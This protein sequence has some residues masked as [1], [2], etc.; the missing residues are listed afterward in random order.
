ME[1][2][3]DKQLLIARNEFNSFLA[4][5][6]NVSKLKLKTSVDFFKQKLNASFE[7]IKCIGYHPEFKELTAT[8]QIK[9]TSGYGGRLCTKG[10]YEY[11]RFYLDYQDGNGWEDMGY[12]ALNVHDIPTK[13]D[14]EGK[15]EKPIDYVVRLGIQ[16]KIQ[17]CSKP[18]LPRVKAV[19]LWNTIPTANDP[20]LGSGIYTWGDVKEE[21]IQIKP[22]VFQLPQIPDLS[23]LF[24]T[25]VLNSNLSLNAIAN[26]VV[27]GN[28]LLETAKQ[29]VKPSEMDFT[30]LATIYQDKKVEPYRFGFEVLK[31]VQANPSKAVVQNINSL[32]DIADLPYADSFAQLQK[33]KCNTNYEELYCVGADYNQEALIGTLKIKRPFGFN[34]DLC[35]QG[36]KEYV[37]FWLQTE[38]NCEWIHAGT[39]FVRV[40]DIQD[41]PD[42]GLSYSVIL[43][44]DFSPLKKSCEE[45]QVLKVRAILSWNQPPQE[46]ECSGWGNV[47][48]SYIQLKPSITWNGNGPKLI[49]VGGIATDNIDPSTGLTLPGAKIEFNQTPTYD[50]SPF[51]GIIVIQGVSAPL[52]GQKYKVLVKNITTGLSYYL[53]NNLALL[54]YNLVTG[55]I[56]HETEVPIN[57]EYTYRSYQDNIGSILARFTP[58]TNDLFEIRIEHPDGTFDSQVIQ[59]D[60]TSPQLELTLNTVDG[61]KHNRNQ[62]PIKGSFTVIENYLQRYSIQSSLNG[63]YTKVGSTSGSGQ[64]EIDITEDVECGKITLSATEK[65]IYNSV[66]TGIGRTIERIVCLA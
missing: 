52:E 14:C 63:L 29:K 36:S 27:G 44:Y 38:D 61:C 19:L 53:N 64:F 32:F 55:Q 2:L 12:V 48:E 57:N 54:G 65:R 16:P 21:H 40:K 1:E 28:D 47:I 17:F 7:S 41:I 34:G 5:G 6:K 37:S 15:T 50:N 59:M 60:N 25:A 66:R 18:N 22:F 23:A 30:D 13:K 58:S 26:T 31:E 8:I 3:D 10:S 35:T 43:P 24:E 9:R 33:L 39:T 46:M 45:P 62:G 56:T 20:T 11:V 42:N 4:L 51:G 49:T